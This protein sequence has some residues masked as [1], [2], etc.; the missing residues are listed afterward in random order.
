VNI[1]YQFF[2]VYVTVERIDY[3]HTGK[4]QLAYELNKSN[5][6]EKCIHVIRDKCA[7][8]VNTINRNYF[9]LERFLLRRQ[10]EF[11]RPLRVRLQPFLKRH[12]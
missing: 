2:L 3:D 7:A 5:N 12:V 6:N 10:Y 11:L 4:F 9:L 1:H 8:D